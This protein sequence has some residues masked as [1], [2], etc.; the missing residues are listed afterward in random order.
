MVILS[1]FLDICFMFTRIFF[2]LSCLWQFSLSAQ[3]ALEKEF[4]N[5]LNDKDLNFAHIG[6]AVTDLQTQ[7][8]VYQYQSQ[9][10]F[11]TASAL[12]LLTTACALENLGEQY[13][14]KTKV[15]T[16]GQVSN[17][18]LEGNLIIQGSGDP[19]FASTRYAQSTSNILEAITN[20]LKKLNIKRITGHI[21]FDIHRFDINPVSPKTY[22]YDL[23]NYF[24][25]AVWPINIDENIFRVTF[26]RSMLT[27]DSTKILKIDPAIDLK[28]DN[29][30]TI[31]GKSDEA[32]IYCA[33]YATYG[34]VKGT[35]PPSNDSYTIKGA[36]PQPMDFFGKALIRQLLNNGIEVNKDLLYLQSPK[37]LQTMVWEHAS[38]L[39]TEIIKQ[40]NLYSINIYAEA[41]IRAVAMEKTGRSLGEEGVKC[42]RKFVSGLRLD[43]AQLN[44]CDGSGISPSNMCSPGLMSDV[45]ARIHTKPWFDSFH[46]S[47]SMSGGNGTLSNMGKGTLLEGRLRAKSGNMDGIS[48]YAG[49]IKTQSGKTM[50]FAIFINNFKADNALIKKKIEHLLIQVAAL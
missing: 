34:Y 36:I 45:L 3:T 14:F 30:V 38:P 37:P 29:R 7:S 9:K 6:F 15:Y 27:G 31:A 25:G 4:N 18:V 19:T 11:S 10:W 32:F 23:G 40:T 16:D 41:L 46:N 47:L 44:I 20:A 24:G 2:F 5:L 50:S 49:Y 13:Q 12:K 39:L 42:M 48:S 22:W 33:P 1:I 43:S 21:C 8:K 28:L 35:L 26:S 17:G